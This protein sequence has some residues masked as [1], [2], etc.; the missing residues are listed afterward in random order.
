MA[1]RLT[2]SDEDLAFFRL[3]LD[4]FP[5][6]ESPLRYMQE[7]DREPTE[8]EV[9]FKTLHER[10]LLNDTHSGAAPHVL[11]RLLPVSECNARVVFRV[12]STSDGGS[13][14]F[15]VGDTTAVEYHCEDISHVF[16]PPLTEDELATE[17]A[18]QLPSTTDIRARPLSMTAGDYLVFAVFARD[19]RAKPISEAAD[20]EAPMSIDEVLSYFDEPESHYVKTPSD[21][22]WQ[23]SVDALCQDGVLVKTREGYELHPSL[24]A[25]AREIVADRQ[26][27][28]LRFDYLDEHWLVREISLYPTRDTVYRLGTAVDGS[29]VIEELSTESLGRAIADVVGT[30]PNILAPDLPPMLK[31]SALFA[32]GA[33]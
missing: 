21:E 25:V 6:P 8:P 11:R 30:L 15:Y 18:A 5:A 3:S 16:G 32:R 26:H 24:H 31:G 17:L 23:G 22:S 29:V 9:T 20:D 28:V 19:L 10:R 1:D 33:I 12:G 14:N 27:T 7:E 13:R 4:L 2:L